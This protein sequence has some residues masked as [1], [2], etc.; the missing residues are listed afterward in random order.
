MLS[1]C[2]KQRTFVLLERF[3]EIEE[4]KQHSISLRVQ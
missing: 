1:K 3:E 2:E 4:Q